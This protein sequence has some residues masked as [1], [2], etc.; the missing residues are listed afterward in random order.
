LSAA[1]AC[2]VSACS[3]IG[4][5][6]PTWDRA[7]P[8]DCTHATVSS[9]LDGVFA[10]GLGAAAV[11]YGN[12]AASIEVDEDA[13]FWEAV[14]TDA[15]DKQAKLLAGAATVGALLYTASLVY[16]VNRRGQCKDAEAEWL[17]QARHDARETRRRIQQ[18]ELL[19][20]YGELGYCKR[21]FDRLEKEPPAT[22]ARA[23]RALPDDCRALLEE[24]I[25]RQRQTSESDSRPIW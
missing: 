20:R 9:A 6:A 1:A 7:H 8:L 14:F 23:V 18:R 5:R 2:S 13:D 25:E 17:D 4:V 15:A 12:M 16:G 10:V 22:W 21:L 19:F 24:R 3:F 11:Y